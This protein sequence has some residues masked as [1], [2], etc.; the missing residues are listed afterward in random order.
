MKLLSDVINE[1]VDADGN[2]SSALLKT[3]VIAIRI[4]NSTLTD[5]VNKELDGYDENDDLPEYRIKSARVTMHYRN[6]NIELTKQ[7]VPMTGMKKE[8]R[9][10]LEGV[11]LRQ[12]VAT[13]QSY[14]SAK[15][16]GAL[17]FPISAELGAYVQNH[18]KKTGRTAPNFFIISIEKAFSIHAVAETLA[19][20]RSRLLN[21]ILE[22]EKEFGSITDI[23]SLRAKNQLITTIMYNTITNTGD[24]NTVNTGNSS[25]VNVVVTI[26]KGDFSALENKLRELGVET[27]DIDDLRSVISTDGFDVDNKRYGM[28]V[29]E[30]LKK[31][32]A[33]AVDGSWQI[34]IG[35]AGGVLSE[36]INSYYGM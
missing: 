1:L 2:L 7:P 21:F 14:L 27:T 29:N 6:G 12:A 10:I 9:K 18:I 33:K 34:G 16:G 32:L 19:V 11:N 13:L 31:M 22:L 8:V 23:E 35:T 3:K 15:D 25:A 4:N 36:L 24:G 20:V 28:K 5:W 30:W 17:S 26:N